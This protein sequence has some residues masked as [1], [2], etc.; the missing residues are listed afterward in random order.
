MKNNLKKIMFG[1]GGAL[2]P[3][4]SLATIASCSSTNTF[5]DLGYFESGNDIQ[6]TIFGS[7]DSTITKL[8]EFLTKP[9]E[10][11]TKDAAAVAAVQ[12]LVDVRLKIADLKNYLYVD[13]S[14]YIEP[15]LFIE[16][17][18]EL[19]KNVAS[20]ADYSFEIKLIGDIKNSSNVLYLINNKD[21]YAVGTITIKPKAFNAADL[22][23]SKEKTNYKY[24]G[25]TYGQLSQENAKTETIKMISMNQA[26]AEGK[27]IKNFVQKQYTKL[28][29]LKE[30][31]FVSSYQNAE[32]II[33]DA[34]LRI[35]SNNKLLLEQI[36]FDELSSISREI[37]NFKVS[38]FDDLMVYANGIWVENPAADNKVIKNLV[39]L[40]GKYEKI[41]NRFTFGISK[42][43]FSFKKTL[44][45]IKT[46]LKTQEEWDKLLT[47]Q[48]KIGSL[49]F[50]PIIPADTIKSIEAI[51]Q[52]DKW[53]FNIEWNVITDRSEGDKNVNNGLLLFKENY[54][55]G[56]DFLPTVY[57]L[58]Q[59]DI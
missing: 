24:D 32:G 19:S 23:A 9:K 20:L 12:G 51:F 45:T 50:N 3:V 22:I 10:L 26:I 54:L 40:N 34:T 6:K 37:D 30:N 14:S 21:D 48:D 59:K 46:A 55:A 2:L 13:S 4:L 16:S 49:E 38:N 18:T 8:D 39:K 17:L 47:L 29:L 41:W 15:A 27:M 42:Q 5:N 56:I 35:T 1:L 44:I 7:D 31:N 58:V 25:L 33:Q 11:V 43:V 52:T 53:V 28:G 36:N 57:T